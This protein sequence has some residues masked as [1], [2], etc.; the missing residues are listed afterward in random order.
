VST[1][2]DT[3]AEFRRTAAARLAE[4]SLD[5]PRVLY[6]GLDTAGHGGLNEALASLGVEVK[7][8]IGLDQALSLLESDPC[9]VCLLDLE[10]NGEA[11]RITRAIRTRYP[12]TVMIGIADPSRLDMTSE[13]IRAGL[14]DVLPRRFSPPDFAAV[15]GNARDQAALGDDAELGASGETLSYGVFGQSAAMRAVMDLVLRAASS[16]G[17][18][19]LCGEPGTGRE[20]VAR[21]IHSHSARGRAP[22]V[23]LDCSALSPDDV[24]G[25]LFGSG[26]QRG[27]SARVRTTDDRIDRAS[28][29]CEASGGTLL[30]EHVTG[31][32]PKA[33]RK[34]ARLLR[35][36]EAIV[37][38][39]SGRVEIDIR[40]IA[41]VEP[42]ADGTPET[43]GLE[44]DLHDRVS[45]IRIDVPPL[46]HRRE[47]IPVLAVHFMKEICH[48]EGY[49]IKTLTKPALLLLSAMPWHGNA[50]ELR[51]LL[52]RVVHVASRGVIPLEEVLPHVRLESQLEASHRP[53]TLREARERFERDY[54]AVVLQQHGGRMGEAAEALGLQRTNLYRKIRQL[55]IPR[56]KTGFAAY[57]NGYNT[58]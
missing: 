12:R 3:G 39:R 15:I 33:Q 28:L 31:M 47:D 5:L 49:R 44:P 26:R 34:L 17:G 22:F 38:G 14:F 37:D 41:A 42:A 36:R 53:A 20:M 51:A 54:I 19:L 32:D 7:R 56:P 11:V 25:E 55:N 2:H 24:A 23:A 52:E 40:P 10:T 45:V 35:R 1:D 43:T 21:A 8:A 6:V 30:L 29:L 58:L 57:H 46:R 48:A 27:S 9:P 16:R 18:V 13:A 50:R 4:G